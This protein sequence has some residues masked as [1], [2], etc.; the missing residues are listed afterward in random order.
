[1]KLGCYEDKEPLLWECNMSEVAKKAR[2]TRR[3]KYGSKGFGRDIS[4]EERKWKQAAKKS[5]RTGKNAVTFTKVRLNKLG[6][7]YVE[8]KSRKGYP[9]KGVID[10]V[11]TKLDR[12]K[13]DKL[14]LILF[15]VKGGSARIK[16]SEKVRL[17]AAVK[18]VQVTFNWAR[19]PKNHVIFY[20][21]PTD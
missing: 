2:T 18:K 1:M 14:H 6:W 8:F 13:A 3:K 19:K 21:E 16:N 7:R 12:K 5:H 20:R 11:A 4:E 15:Q 9:Q 10:L 17:K